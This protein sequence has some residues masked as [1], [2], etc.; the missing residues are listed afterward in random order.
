MKRI[1]LVYS[2]LMLSVLA[3]GQERTAEGHRQRYDRLVARVG[4]DGVGVG[5]LIERW[6]ADWPDDL[7]MLQAK[8]LYYF[9]KSR[10]AQVI[11]LPDSKFLGMEPILSLQDS[12]GRPINYFQEPM[13]EDSLFRRADQAIDRAVALAPER[14]DLRFVKANALLNYEKGSPDMTLDYI[15]RLIDDNYARHPQWRYYDEDVSAED[16]KAY[17]QDYC[18]SLFKLGTPHGYE[19]FKDLAEK[20]LKHNPGDAV[21]MDDIGSYYLIHKKDTKTAL[22]YYDKVLKKHPDDLTAIRN[23]ILIARHGRDTRLEKKYLPMLAK[24]GETEAERL[25]AEGRLSLLK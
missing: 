6:E 9:T 5:T 10:T 22:K 7:D 4:A 19:A 21:F 14:L 17:I 1:V 13:Y 3:F 18:F 25:S 20:M 8:F 23:C 12:L 16:F 15:R 2:F 11:T 24:Y